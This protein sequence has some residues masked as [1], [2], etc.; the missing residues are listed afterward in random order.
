MPRN[1]SA[2][3]GQPG[4]RGDG[5][6]GGGDGEVP[7]AG[8]VRHVH[9]GAHRARAGRPA[10][11][12]ARPAWATP[13]ASSASRSAV[14]D[15]PGP[16]A[17]R[18]RPGSSRGSAVRT[19]A[20]RS[21]T[22]GSGRQ[23][24]PA[25][26][27][28]RRARPAGAAGAGRRGARRARAAGIPSGSPSSRA[29]IASRSGVRARHAPCSRPPDRRPVPAHRSGMGH[30]PLPGQM[31]DMDEL[32]QASRPTPPGATPSPRR[33]SSAPPSP[34]SGGCARRSATAGSADDLT[35]ETYLRAFGV[36]APLRGPL[37]GAH[38]AAGDRPPGLRRRRP[39]RAAAGGSPSSGTTPTSSPLAAGAPGRPDDA[40]GRGRRRRRPARPA[41]RRPPRGLRADPAARALLRRGRRGGRLPGRHDP[42]PRRRGPAA[43]LSTPCAG[44]EERRPRRATP[45]R[46]DARVHTRRPAGAPMLPDGRAP[47]LER[48]RPVPI[49]DTEPTRALQPDAQGLE[50]LPAVHRLRGEPGG[51]HRRPRRVR[52]RP[53]APRRAGRSSCATSSTP[54][55][56]RRT[57]SSG[58]STPASSRRST[59]RTSTTSPATST[60]SWTT[61]RPPPTWSS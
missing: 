13:T 9:R 61:S 6:E 25:G 57:R 16:G 20:V 40:V 17:P 22:G 10:T 19:A 37:L 47:A 56:R 1:G 45:L 15:E 54:A 49:P 32:E 52:P 4:R 29:E 2:P 30:R 5:E 38:L 42:L 51:G 39:R 55:T 28:R 21:G 60:T 14:S 34:T 18:P 11:G 27:P 48:R 58:S 26:D 23:P 46:P 50:L 44:V 8:L 12:Q 7:G 3:G 43:D 35:Q 53:R 31:D 59:A 36:A 33:R 41:G 24:R